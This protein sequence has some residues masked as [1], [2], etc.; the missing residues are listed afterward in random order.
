M[1]RFA[2]ACRTRA[3]PR[4][5]TCAAASRTGH[6]GTRWRSST[7]A[8]G[9]QSGKYEIIGLSQNI[10]E[11]VDARDQASVMNDRLEIAMSAASAGVYEIDLRSSER[12]TSPQYQALAG[13]EA[14]ARRAM[15]PFGMYHDDDIPAVRES[16]ERCSAVA[17]RRVD[18]RAALSPGRQRAV[19]APVHAGA[20]QRAWRADARDRPD[21]GYPAAE[22]AGTCA[23]RS[24][25]TG[26][27]SDHREI[28]LPRVDEPRDPGRR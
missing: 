8:A 19:G 26:G 12:W 25:E 22:G 27:S 18:R 7:R 4:R 21:A 16:W 3:A 5:C 28:E 17:G 2:S 1:H 9:C 11:L 20:A 13:Q 23:D 10:T 14:L 6:G 24:Q 15:M